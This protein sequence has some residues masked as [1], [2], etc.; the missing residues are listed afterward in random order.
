MVRAFGIDISAFNVLMMIILIPVGWGFIQKG[1]IQNARATGGFLADFL[2][3]PISSV[4]EILG[5]PRLTPKFGDES[6][7]IDP[8]TTPA[9]GGWLASLRNFWNTPLGGDPGD[10]TTINITTEP[11]ATPTQVFFPE[12]WKIDP[13][14]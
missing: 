9:D 4:L 14:S 1:G 2:F 3:N 10:R 12:S 11:G 6:Q 8:N 7:P 13:Q 5:L